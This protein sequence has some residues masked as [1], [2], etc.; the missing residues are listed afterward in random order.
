ML[1]YSTAVVYH[2]LLRKGEEKDLEDMQKK[3]LWIVYGLNHSYESCLNKS[4]PSTLKDRR[5]E[6]V[7]KFA[8]KKLVLTR[9]TVNGFLGNN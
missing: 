3:A 9:N 8:K 5:L 4:G 2:S 1:D 7:D 6:L